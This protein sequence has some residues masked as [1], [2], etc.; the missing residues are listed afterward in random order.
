MSAPELSMWSLTS[1]I[2]WV[3]FPPSSPVSPFLPCLKTLPLSVCLSVRAWGY[4]CV[5]KAYLMH[6]LVEERRWKMFFSRVQD[7]QHARYNRGKGR[8]KREGEGEG[9]GRDRVHLQRDRKISASNFGL[10]LS[11]VIIRIHKRSAISTQGLSVAVMALQIG[12]LA[13]AL[14]GDHKAHPVPFQ[15][16]AA[17]VILAASYVCPPSAFL[18]ASHTHS[19]SLSC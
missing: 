7:A 6:V 16:V 11:T 13:F 9:E 14:T 19:H 18:C 15:H 2:S 5:L 3:S 8:V 12:M 17:P 10:M 4:W 1:P